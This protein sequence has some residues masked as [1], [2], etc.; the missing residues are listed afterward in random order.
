MYTIC[1][2]IE[3]SKVKLS[4]VKEIGGGRYYRY[5]SY[6]G[7]QRLYIQTPTFSCSGPIRSRY[8]EAKQLAIPVAAMEEVIKL[9]AFVKEQTILPANAPDA[10]RKVVAENDGLHSSI[11]KD[12]AQYDR[13]FVTIDDEAPVFNLLNR[14]LLDIAPAAG[15]YRCL[16]HVRGIYLGSHGTTLKFQSL[17]LRVLQMLYAEG[18][19]RPDVCSFLPD[20][21]EEAADAVFTTVDLAELP[22]IPSDSGPVIAATS[23]VIRP[24]P[25]PTMLVP[26]PPAKAKP[27]TAKQTIARRRKAALTL[28][29]PGAQSAAK[30]R[31]T[32]RDI[33]I[34]DLCAQYSRINYPTIDPDPDDFQHR[35]EM[36]AEI[37]DKL[38]ALCGPDWESTVYF[39]Y[40]KRKF[41]HR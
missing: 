18:P 39:D 32:A 26:T 14:E 24:T 41:E 31:A 28:D 3:T 1:R 22:A 20:T 8:R 23:S 9:D 5:V 40:Q 15:R 16:I 36:Q 27:A 7:Y 29:I 2:Q 21:V 12:Y 33:E 25:P 34:E 37:V 4:A 17:Q 30:I 38:T 6:D 13:L 19:Q 10:W 35:L 11:H